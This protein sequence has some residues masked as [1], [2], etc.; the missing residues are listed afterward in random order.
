MNSE[1]IERFSRQ[2]LLPGWNLKVQKTYASQLL[3]VDGSLE[4]VALYAAAAG[5]GRLLLV[6]S[7][8]ADLAQY[9]RRF[10][11]G[12]QVE[13]LALGA[14][15]E[16]NILSECSVVFCITDSPLAQLLETPGS[17]TP[18]SYRVGKD[19]FVRVETSGTVDNSRASFPDS[20]GQNAVSVLALTS[21]LYALT[22]A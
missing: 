10:N 21:Y 14:V 22:T 18:I 17:R 2:L 7:C 16:R 5:I 9:L 8:R 20:I 12:T 4:S 11:P 15:L 19:R 13:N 3:A 6:D 1:Q